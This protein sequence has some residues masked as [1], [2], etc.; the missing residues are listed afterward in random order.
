MTSPD[1]VRMAFHDEAWTVVGCFN[2]NAAIRSSKIGDCIPIES[3]DGSAKK[4]ERELCVVVANDNNEEE[5]MGR[6]E[7]KFHFGFGLVWNAERWED[8]IECSCLTELCRSLGAEAGWW[9]A[10]GASRFLTCLALV[11]RD[12]DTRT[13]SRH[14]NIIVVEKMILRRCMRTSRERD[15]AELFLEHGSKQLV[16]G[17]SK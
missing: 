11:Y 15:R 16:E 17:L 7:K 6:I 4:S 1:P 12:D 14:C 13:K 5:D 8:S 2:P 3:K 9:K 10:I